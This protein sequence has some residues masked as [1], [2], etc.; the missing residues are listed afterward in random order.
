M[1]RSR[2]QIINYSI[3]QTPEAA[4]PGALGGDLAP[5][6]RGVFGLVGLDVALGLAGDD[7]GAGAGKDV[8]AAATAAAATSAPAIGGRSRAQGIHR[9]TG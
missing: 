5:A 3:F 1:E 8:A 7:P 2:Y 4:R 6:G 9:Q